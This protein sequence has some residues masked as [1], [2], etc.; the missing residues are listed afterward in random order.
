MGWDRGKYYSRSS[1]VNGRV[2]RE[3][4]GTGPLAERVAELDALGRQR[5][6]VAR[7]DLRAEREELDALDAPFAELDE[8]AE[9][10]AHAALAAAGYRRHHRGEWRRR[11]GAD[12]GTR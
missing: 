1:K 11:R 10:V 6:E 9:L 3:Y 4:I 2:R 12:E 7:E 8:L 5:K